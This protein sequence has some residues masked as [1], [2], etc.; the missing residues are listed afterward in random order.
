MSGPQAVAKMIRNGGTR[1]P[2]DTKRQF[3]YLS[4][5]GTVPLQLPDSCGGPELTVSPDKFFETAKDWALG[6]GRWQ[7]GQRVDDTSP[8]LT[9]HLVASF[10]PGTDPQLAERVARN[11]ASRLFDNPRMRSSFP[12][13]APAHQFP[14]ITALHTD[15]GHPHIHIV[16]CR[17]STEG[18]WLKIANRQGERSDPNVLD[19]FTF[20]DLRYELVD[21]A[22]EEGLDLEATTRLVRGLAPRDFSDPEY[23]RQEAAVREQWLRRAASDDTF[24]RVT[25][26]GGE[27]GS[28]SSGS[29]ELDRGHT[30]EPEWRAG[31][32]SGSP[33]ESDRR[34]AGTSDLNLTD[35]DDELEEGPPLADDGSEGPG[36]MDI[37]EAQELQQITVLGSR[38]SISGSGASTS[39]VPG[40]GHVDA[41]GAG[42]S[43]RRRRSEAFGAEGSDSEG[44]SGDPQLETRPAKKG[45]P[46]VLTRRA[47]AFEIAAEQARERWMELAAKVKEG[48]GTRARTRAVREADEA[49]EAWIAA[50]QAAENDRLNPG[51]KRKREETSFVR[52]TRARVTS[53]DREAGNRDL[54]QPSAG[55]GHE[56]PVQSRRNGNDNSR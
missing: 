28:E 37:D 45:R 10:P 27:S 21:A 34:R 3:N 11:F 52:S 25:D 4:Q 24:V 51:R 5:G 55:A 41:E 14:Y 1:K 16:V 53:G 8:D 43:R 26:A 6:T 38:Q 2:A 42:P 31:H 19:T 35:L 46:N 12:E 30:P 9:T 54:P 32:T 20:A 39:E 7:K 44:P 18:G 48:V 33:P 22:F 17:S 49:K 29:V 50:K 36:Q 56:N 15:K 40:D 13:G 47:E 23:R